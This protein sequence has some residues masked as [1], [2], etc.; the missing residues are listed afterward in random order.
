[1]PIPVLGAFVLTSVLATTATTAWS[2]EPL[3]GKEAVHW[4]QAQFH[5]RAKV[6][7][8][9]GF[10]ADL[11]PHG[12]AQLRQE[13]G[14]ETDGALLTALVRADLSRHREALA[15]TVEEAELLAAGEFR[16]HENRSSCE[17]ILEVLERNQGGL[18]A[19]MG[20][21]ANRIRSGAAVDM[22]LE[23]AQRLLAGCS[24]GITD[25]SPLVPGTGAGSRAP[26]GTVDSVGEH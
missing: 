11:E 12:R 17:G 8:G 4:V 18:A 7:W 20:Y 2:G 3:S 26:L 14:V 16:N 25:R 10:L 22:E 1:M 6:I 24:A 21:L 19:P 13:H 23:F 9:C 5:E 15:V